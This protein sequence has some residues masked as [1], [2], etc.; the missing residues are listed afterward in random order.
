MIAREAIMIDTDGEEVGQVNGLSVIGLGDISFGRPSR[1]TAGVGIGQ[2]GVVDIEREAKL[3][4]P[5]HTKG[6][7]ILAGYLVERFAQDKPLSLSANLVF[8]Q[9][10]SGVEGDSASSTE[11]YAILSRLAGLPIQQGMAVTGS[12]NQKGEIQ[13]IGGVNEK[14][15]GFFEICKTKGLTGRQGVLIPA[16]NLPNLMLKDEVVRA[17]L[18][19]KFHVWPVTTVEEGIELLTG[20]KAGRRL[21]DGSYEAG[22]VFGLA[23]QQLKKLAQTMK[24][25]DAPS[26]KGKKAAEA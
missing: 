2:A 10:Y 9:S 18:E 6:V 25:F 3:G 16:S 7:L 4:G 11:L 12:V 26:E 14:I 17:V 1:I 24:D 5:I 15:E 8:E 21:E 19:G 22:T 13:A 23:D 20:T